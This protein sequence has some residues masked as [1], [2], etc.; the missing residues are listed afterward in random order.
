MS[1]GYTG[2]MREAAAEVKK[3]MRCKNCHYFNDCNS[4]SSRCKGTSNNWKSSC[5]YLNRKS[6]IDHYVHQTGASSYLVKVLK[7]FNRKVFER[8]AD[9]DGWDLDVYV[10]ENFG[11]RFW[12]HKK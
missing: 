11:C 12:K 6:N 7:S 10:N 1:D 8:R 2:M 9:P 5:L 4:M 3:Y